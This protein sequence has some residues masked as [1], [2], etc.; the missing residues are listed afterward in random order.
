MKKVLQTEDPMH[1]FLKQLRDRGL[2][3]QAILDVGANF[4]QWSRL[5]KRVFPEANCFLIEP[6]SEMKSHLDAFCLEYP[7]SRW[8]LAGAGAT[9]GELTLTVWDDLAGSSFLP[10]ESEELQET[11]KQRCVPILT[12]DSLLTENKIE[13]PQIVK[14]DVQGFELEVLRGGNGLIGKTEVFILEVSLFAFLNR[15]P[16]FHEVIAFMADRGYYVYD[17]IDF[18]RRPYDGALGQVDVCFVKSDGFL[19]A[20][21]CWQ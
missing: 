18:L 5:A 11:G 16:I 2:E 17:F 21:N 3:C 4:G 20:E 9:T 10:P 6:Q 13:I 14:L 1:F 7:G 15:Q 8:F 19:R 12:I